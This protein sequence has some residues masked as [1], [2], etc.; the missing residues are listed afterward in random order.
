MS[1]KYAIRNKNNLLLFN[2]FKVSY[3][4]LFYDKSYQLNLVF[5]F[6][7]VFPK[8]N[9]NHYSFVIVT[10]ITIFCN[11]RPHLFKKQT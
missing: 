2:G 6:P 4:H 10:C 1:Y 5:E 7:S 3:F 8:I 9:I 11:Y